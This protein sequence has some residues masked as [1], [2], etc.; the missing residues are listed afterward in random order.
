MNTTRRPADIHLMRASHTHVQPGPIVTDTTPE[1]RLVHR[2]SGVESGAGFRAVFASPRVTTYVVLAAV[3]CVM[4]LLVN[5]V[6]NFPLNDDWSYGHAV[7]SL[8]ERGTLRFTGWTSMPLVVQV[9][10]GALF[11]FPFGFSFTVL[12]LSTLVLGLAGVLA[13]YELLCEAGSRRG[14]AIC[15]ALLLAVNPIYFGLSHTFMTD[16]SSWDHLE[17]KNNG[18]KADNGA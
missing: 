14:L 12:R 15:G 3:W 1:L 5:P 10:W 6:G 16:V 7:Q 17:P 18:V 4:T 8:V 2:S 11:C 13:A 9:L